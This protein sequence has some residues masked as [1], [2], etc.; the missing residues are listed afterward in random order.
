MIAGDVLTTGEVAQICD[1]SIGTVAKWIDS[2]LLRG[3]RLPTAAGGKLRHR[4]VLR[5]DLVVFARAHEMP[6]E[7]HA[8]S[9]SP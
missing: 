6:I 7:I 5:Q 1:V 4:R 2:G 8:Q 3:H 9:E